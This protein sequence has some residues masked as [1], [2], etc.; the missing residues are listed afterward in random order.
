[1]ALEARILF[2]LSLIPFV[3]C[4]IRDFAQK[5][6]ITDNRYAKRVSFKSILHK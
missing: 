1:M 4:G 6:N 2:I 5:L 3:P